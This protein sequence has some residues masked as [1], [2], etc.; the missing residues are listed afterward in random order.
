MDIHE[1]QVSCLCD[2]SPKS[3]LSS[4]CYVNN[5]VCN[6]VRHFSAVKSK[7]GTESMYTILFS[8]LNE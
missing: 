3:V 1:Y 5:F 8:T 7:V 2:Y 4:K 6:N